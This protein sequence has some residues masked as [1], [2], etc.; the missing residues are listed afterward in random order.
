MEP[1]SRV[2]SAGSSQ[3]A[4]AAGMEGAAEIISREET[5]LTFLLR[6]ARLLSSVRSDAGIGDRQRKPVPSP[7]LASLHAG[8]LFSN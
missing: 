4:I 6:K 5:V 1:E 3:C 2:L 7:F 8:G